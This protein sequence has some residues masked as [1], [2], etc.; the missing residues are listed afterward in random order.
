MKENVLNAHM[1]PRSLFLNKFLMRVYFIVTIF[2]LKKVNQGFQIL[3]F[4][5]RFYCTDIPNIHIITLLKS[6]E[7]FTDS[8]WFDPRFS[9]YRPFLVRYKWGRM[10]GGGGWSQ[11]NGNQIQ[12]DTLPR[13]YTYAMDK[14][15]NHF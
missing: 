6:F 4:Q 7:C 11:L 12:E 1:N 3:G 5:L 2:S 8:S 10:G 15:Y 13:Y 9:L 14:H